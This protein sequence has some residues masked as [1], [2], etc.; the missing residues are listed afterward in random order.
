MRFAIVKCPCWLIA[1][2][3]QY[4]ALFNP[5]VARMAR[6]AVGGIQHETNVF[7]PYK[8]E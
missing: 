4:N 6:I 3:R 7:A 1:I 5:G 2:N 8:A